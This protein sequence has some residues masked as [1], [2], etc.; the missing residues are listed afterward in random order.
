MP[1]WVIPAAFAVVG[2]VV[3]VAATL[4]SRDARVIIFGV[5][6]FGGGGIFLGVFLNW[7]SSPRPP[8]E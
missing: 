6:A 7:I 4:T 1:D 5:L 3:G 2:M 8:Q